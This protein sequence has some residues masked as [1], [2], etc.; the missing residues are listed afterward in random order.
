M[1]KIILLSL[2]LVCLACPTKRT[3]E[4]LSCKVHNPHKKDCGHYGINQAQCEKKGCC[5]KKDVDSKIPWCFYGQEDSETIYATLGESCSIDKEL[6]EECGYY[7]IDKKECEE[8]G[9]CWKVDDDNSII[10]WCFHG[11]R[12]V[13]KKKDSAVIK[14]D[15]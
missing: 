14:F 1:N 15:F 7:G 11:L 10:P 6:R 2:L 4:N 3:K 8:R 12:D 9:C 13:E 5:W